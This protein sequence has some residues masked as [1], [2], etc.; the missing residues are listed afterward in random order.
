MA[1]L[2]FVEESAQMQSIRDILADHL[3]HLGV[4]RPAV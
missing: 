1:N 4:E 2:V 3:A